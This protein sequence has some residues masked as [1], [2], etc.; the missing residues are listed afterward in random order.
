VI[1]IGHGRLHL[2]LDLELRSRFCAVIEAKIE[3]FLIAPN[4]AEDVGLLV[5][6]F[7]GMDMNARKAQSSRILGAKSRKFNNRSE[8]LRRFHQCLASRSF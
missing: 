4:E 6:I 7:Y 8:G 1:D 3:A 2:I 5:K